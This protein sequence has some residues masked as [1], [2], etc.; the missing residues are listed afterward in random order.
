MLWHA[1]NICVCI[2]Q[3][4]HKNLTKTKIW[5]NQLLLWLHKSIQ[6]NNNIVAVCSWAMESFNHTFMH[7]CNHK[8]LFELAHARTQFLVNKSIKFIS[9]RVIMKFFFFFCLILIIELGVGDYWVSRH[10]FV[11]FSNTVTYRWSNTYRQ[12]PC[13]LWMLRTVR[14]T[15][16]CLK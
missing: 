8:T 1:A 9:N 12:T 14:G 13:L 2:S 3:Q 10:M 11:C 15:R 5:K 7:A 16:L 6:C 4:E